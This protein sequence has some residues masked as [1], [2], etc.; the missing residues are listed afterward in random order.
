MLTCHPHL[1]LSL[2]MS[3]A[4]P[5][6]PLPLWRG[7][8]QFHFFFFILNVVNERADRDPAVCFCVES[9]YTE[10]MHHVTVSESSPIDVYQL[11][12]QRC[13]FSCFNYSWLP[14]RFQIMYKVFLPLPPHALVL[15][16]D[17]N[18]ISQW[19]D[20]VSRIF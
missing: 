1:V 13:C 20:A 9:P 4:T 11:F 2:R 5:L 14:R 18:F 10:V 12:P 16:L 19:N 17:S 7:E 8:G 6:H 3:E 15:A